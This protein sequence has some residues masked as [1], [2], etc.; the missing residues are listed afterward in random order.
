MGNE[1][2]KDS[3]FYKRIENNTSICKNC[4]RKLK[5]YSSPHHTYPDCVSPHVEYENHT[6]SFW[7]D[8][9]LKTA[10]PSVKRVHCSCGDVD[11]AKIRPVNRDEV[12]KMS[13]RIIEN[14]RTQDFIIDED[15]F[16]G[17]IKNNIDNGDFRFNE[18]KYFEEATDESLLTNG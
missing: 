10:R 15:A 6:E 7:F 2:N 16:F 12:M 5:E 11:G 17:Y 3:I 8:D 1:L 13:S 9:K 18:E 14:L 4:Y